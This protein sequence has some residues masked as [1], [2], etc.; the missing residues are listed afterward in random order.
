MLFLINLHR[1]KVEWASKNIDFSQGTSL[2]LVIIPLGSIL[3]LFETVILAK[4]NSGKTGTYHLM[5]KRWVHNLVPSHFNLPGIWDQGCNNN[6]FCHG[7]PTRRIMGDSYSDEFSIPKEQSRR[8]L[9]THWATEILKTCHFYFLCYCFCP[10]FA[11]VLGAWQACA[12][13]W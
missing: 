1:R 13:Y 10:L 4:E 6:N 11:T 2:F 5:S 8:D 12:H 9:L 3:V 7:V